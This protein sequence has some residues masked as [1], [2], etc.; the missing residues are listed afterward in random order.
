MC[1]DNSDN[2]GFSP[3]KYPIEDFL[4]YLIKYCIYL[5]IDILNWLNIDDC[6]IC[7][8]LYSDGCMCGWIQGQT[9]ID[10]A[11]DYGGFTD[12]EIDEFMVRYIFL[13]A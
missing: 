6:N 11:K 1:S 8:Y 12:A 2:F 10:W 7:D 3:N 4:L 5:S 13:K 9:P